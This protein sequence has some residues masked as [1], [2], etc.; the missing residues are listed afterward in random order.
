[1]KQDQKAGCQAEGQAV[2]HRPPAEIQASGAALQQDKGNQTQQEQP[3]GAYPQAV[4]GQNNAAIAGGGD[5]K[6]KK[7]KQKKS[8]QAGPSGWRPKNQTLTER[9]L[10]R[11]S[12]FIHRG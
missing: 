11:D 6:N 8:V 10:H 5:P 7:S 3:G 1:A 4:L 2:L 12:C 9:F